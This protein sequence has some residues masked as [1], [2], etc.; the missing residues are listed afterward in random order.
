MKSEEDE[1]FTL[2][3]ILRE[4]MSHKHLF[5]GVFAMFFYMSAEACTAGFFIPYLKTVLHF[6]DAQSASYL[7]L[8]YFF[9]VVMGIAAV[10]ILKYIKAYK[11]V[12]VYAVGMAVFFFICIFLIPDIMN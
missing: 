11:L 10:C 1:P 9:T 6:N 4:G 5:Y 7:T 12:G 3:G 2:K 8:Y